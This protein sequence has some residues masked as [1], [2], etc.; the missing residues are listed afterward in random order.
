MFNSDKP[1]GG[2]GGLLK[3]M[4]SVDEEL[5]A[6]VEERKAR[7]EDES[8]SEDSE[9]VVDFNPVQPGVEIIKVPE[10]SERE[11]SKKPDFVP[12]LDI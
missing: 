5:A 1:G 4:Q 9:N 2:L 11:E 7:G 8:S 6:R 3:G 12:E 10:E